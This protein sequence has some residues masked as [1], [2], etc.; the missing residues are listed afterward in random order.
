M[1][2]IKKGT[3]TAENKENLNL[4][5]FD[6]SSS[7]KGLYKNQS[8]KENQLSEFNTLGRKV[9]SYQEFI[10]QYPD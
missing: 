5:S 4:K 6:K 3:N 9:I 1:D 10:K 8:I 7:R 2:M